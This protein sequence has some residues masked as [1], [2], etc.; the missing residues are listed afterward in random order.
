MFKEEHERPSTDRPRRSGRRALTT[1]LAMMLSLSLAALGATGPA[2]A[3]ETP[4]STADTARIDPSRGQ[5]AKPYLGWSS[6]S[7]QATTYPGVNPDGGGSWLN[8]KH[9]LQQADVIDKLL[10]KHGYEYVNIDAGWQ[11]GADRYGRPTVNAERFPDGIGYLADYVHARGLKLGVYTV[12][13]LGKDAYADGTMPVYGAPQCRSSDLVYPDLRTTNGWDMSYKINFDSPCAQLYIN[14]IA[15]VFAGWGVDF[16]KIDGVGPGSFKGGENYDNTTDIAAWSK[17]LHATGRPITFVL[18]WALAHTE[19]DTWKNYS[20]GWRIDTDVECYCNTLVTWNS[21]VKGRWNDVV[22][23]IDDAGPGHWNNLDTL[24]VGVGEMDGL[25]KDE[26][27]STMTLWAIESA[28]LYLGDDLT[29]LDR[30]GLSLITNDE[31]IAVDQQGNPARP[32][33]QASRQ[34]VWYAKNDDGSYTVALFNLDD[35]RTADV[36]A[37]FADLG[38]DG[39]AD[40]RDLWQ[41]KGLGAATQKITESLPPHGSRLFRVTPKKVDLTVP[42]APVDLHGTASGAGSVSLAWRTVTPGRQPEA[43]TFDVYANGSL[44]ASDVAEHDATIDGLEPATGYRFAV[45][46]RSADGRTSRPS[47]PQTITTSAADGPTTYEAEDAGNDHTGNAGVAD[48]AGCSGGAKIGNLGGDATLTIKDVTAP[49]DGRYL[50]KIDYVDGDVSREA[51]FTVDGA[52]TGT[53]I[54]FPGTGDNDWDHP[55]SIMVPITLK[56]AATT[57]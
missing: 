49:T 42:A 31:V 30:Y 20:N 12:V 19:A 45:V 32:V 55:Q 50:V 54:T 17:A 44:V 18:S 14:S 40:V 4:R 43:T 2:L 22:Q 21:S 41:R 35:Q 3:E 36:T 37:R 53:W 27:Q 5:A 34:Q 56:G 51:Q 47:S 33:S 13:G 52:D 6:W 7:L 11:D 39:T 57:S 24:N 8:Q 46:A 38:F 28:P 26:R 16:L 23:W 25:N 29:K 48:C 9:V 10:K 1:A 15:D